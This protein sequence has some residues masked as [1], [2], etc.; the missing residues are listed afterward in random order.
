MRCIVAR[1]PLLPHLTAQLGQFRR[2]EAP[3]GRGFLALHL[4][5]LRRT[6]GVDRLPDFM[7]GGATDLQETR[8]GSGGGTQAKGQR[9]GQ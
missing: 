3:P 5:T 8:G 1:R 9:R 7:A 6:M 2:R 4:F